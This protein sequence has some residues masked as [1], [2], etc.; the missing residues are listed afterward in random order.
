MNKI[1]NI[2]ILIFLFSNPANA[3][4][5]QFLGIGFYEDNY[6]NTS[7]GDTM[8][9]PFTINGG[10]LT[11]AS[12]GTF[13]N[14]V[15]AASFSGDGANLTAITAANISAGSLLNT[16]IASSIAVDAVFS[17]SIKDDEIVNA[18]INS[19]AGIDALKLADGTVTNAELQYSSTT[20]SNI[21]DQIDLKVDLTESSSVIFQN[22]DF[23]VGSS[24]LIVTNGTIGIGQAIPDEK[25]H[26][27]NGSIKI[28]TDGGSE[29]IIFQDDSEQIT[30]YHDLEV[31]VYKASSESVTDS[32]VLQDDDDLVVALKANTVYH[33]E[34]RLHMESSS[35][36]PDFKYTFS[37]PAGSTV[38]AT[39]FGAEKAGAFFA[40]DQ[41]LDLEEN[42]I[43][44]SAGVHSYLNFWGMVET[45]S[46]AGDIKF[47]WAQNTS[48][49]SATWVGT[50]SSFH[51]REV[52]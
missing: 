29:G 1:L 50:Y 8:E 10:S 27:K 21:Q 31:F 49:G 47:Q 34:G 24:T 42:T 45:D 11:V 7:G 19:S 51:V 38:A 35:A 4:F 23:S 17:E 9:G 5:E 36:V 48:N 52:E 6:V 16:V 22:A 14:Q 26:I 46:T 33:F 15:K 2:L 28:S 32:D 20:S 25:L 39:G 44:L 37:V 13:T 41:H 3:W 30:A 18:D 40:T 43:A 12:S